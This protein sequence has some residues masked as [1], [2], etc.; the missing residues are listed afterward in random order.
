MADGGIRERRLQAVEHRLIGDLAGEA[1]VTRPELRGRTAHQQLAPVRGRAGNV[2]D[3]ARIEPRDVIGERLMR[4]RQHHRAA[5]E[6]GAEEDLQAAIA[7]DVVEC[8]PHRR[9]S[10]RRTFGDDGAGECFQR[11]PGDLRHAGRARGEHQP[12]GGALGLRGRG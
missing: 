7:A 2:G 1:D 11:M 8:G 4:I 5:G 10:A 6:H 9:R 12:F 3:A